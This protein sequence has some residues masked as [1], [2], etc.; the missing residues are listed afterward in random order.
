MTPCPL[1]HVSGRSIE[2]TPHGDDRADSEFGGALLVNSRRVTQGHAG[3]QLRHHGV[4]THR[5]QLNDVES[6]HARH[7]VRVRVLDVGGNEK[8]HALENL[9]IGSMPFAVRDS[10]L[11]VDRQ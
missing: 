6:W 9:G 5:R 2:S 11:R 4:E 3:R 8:P 7:P 10:P 1:D